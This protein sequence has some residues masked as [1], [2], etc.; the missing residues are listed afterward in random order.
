MAILHHRIKELNEHFSTNKKDHHSKV[1][2]LKIVSKRRKLLDY[3]KRT[4]LARYKVIIE[5]LGLRK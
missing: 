5:K 2:L 1:G 3:L 4:D